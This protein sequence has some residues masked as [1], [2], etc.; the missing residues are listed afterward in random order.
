VCLDKTRGYGNIIEIEILCDENGVDK[1]REKVSSL[2]K[3]L[4]VAQTPKYVFDERFSYYKKN[5][6]RLVD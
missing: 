4:K 3:K 1:A 2:M 6:R 5:W